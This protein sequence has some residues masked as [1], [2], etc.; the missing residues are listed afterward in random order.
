MSTSEHLVSLVSDSLSSLGLSTG[1]NVLIHADITSIA[2]LCAQSDWTTSVKVLDDAI[3]KTIGPSGN[4]L[5]PAFNWDFCKGTPYNDMLT[6]SRQ[7]V[8]ANYVRRQSRSKRSGHPIFSFSGYGPDID[9]LFEGI[10]NSSF[11][12]N[13]VF[14]RIHKL[15]M[16]LIFFNT[17]FY[18]C[19]F[20]HHIE[21]MMQVPYRYSKNF[22]GQVTI[23]EKTFTDT[24][25]FYVRDEKLNVESYPTRLG[26]KLLEMQ[27]MSF[28]ECDSGKIYCVKAQD[29]YEVAINCLRNDQY[30][31]LKNNPYDAK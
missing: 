24:Y 5:V 13:S 22:T 1:S 19:T 7:G 26:E 25:E 11:G 3:K 20:V 21:H 14:D 18:N 4:I 27:L 12:P 29:V 31:L 30:Y 16:N 8:F 23:N 2:R 17:T 15:N 28:I 6:P 9:S 10:S